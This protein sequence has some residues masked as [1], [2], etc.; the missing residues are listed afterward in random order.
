MSPQPTPPTSPENPTF[1]IVTSAGTIR[2]QLFPKDAP[3]SVANFAKYAKD[4]F[5][6]GTIF[7]RVIK[8]FMIQGGGHTPDGRQ[9]KTGSPIKLEISPKLAHWD[10]A[11]AMARTAVP[12]S[13]T[14]Q[15]YVCH[16]PQAGLDKNYAVFGLVTG[17]KDVVDKIASSP[18]DRADRPKTDVTIQSVTVTGV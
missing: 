7:H 10:G 4:G 14:A 12:D 18:T 1:E 5:Y 8:G 15:F 11:L 9:K 17:G 6:T 16:G 2:G 13:A 3:V